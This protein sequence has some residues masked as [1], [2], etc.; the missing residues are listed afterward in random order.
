MPFLSINDRSKKKKK[1]ER[2]KENDKKSTREI[3]IDSLRQF[4]GSEI[5]CAGRRR[6]A[7]SRLTSKSAAAANEFWRQSRCRYTIHSHGSLK[8][9]LMLAYIIIKISLNSRPLSFLR[10]SY[11]Y[12]FLNR[13]RSI[14]EST[15]VGNPKAT[16]PLLFT[17]AFIK[18]NFIVG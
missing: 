16:N 12:A 11:G 5:S 9:I 4:V 2:V 6:F 17:I 7:D 13:L 3:S 1:T 18:L 10:L 15:N 8:N 14:F